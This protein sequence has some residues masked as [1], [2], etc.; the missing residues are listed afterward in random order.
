MGLVLGFIV[1][2]T[3]EELSP[4]ILD[5]WSSHLEPNLFVEEFHKTLADLIL[6]GFSENLTPFIF[7]L[8]TKEFREQS[9]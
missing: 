6:I 9:V 8:G 1:I 4:E 3:I 7:F 2:V 5:I